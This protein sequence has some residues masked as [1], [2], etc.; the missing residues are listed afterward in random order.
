VAVI[1]A[2][3]SPYAE[4]RQEVRAAAEKEG[5][6]FVEVFVKAELQSLVDRDVK[7]LYR[8]A[9]AG[10][11]EHF[12]G[13]SDPYEPPPSPDVLLQTDKETVE[14]SLGTLLAALDERGLLA[15]WEDEARAS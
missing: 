6:P 4:T 3:I 10:E 12:T 8:K 14:E 11:I 13:V 9:L 5:I 7:G 15:S 1:T 2:A